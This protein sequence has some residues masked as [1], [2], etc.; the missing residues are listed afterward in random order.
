[1]FGLGLLKGTAIG[2]TGGIVIGLA[3]KEACKQ[4]KNKKNKTINNNSSTD[5]TGVNTVDES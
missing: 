3:I 4:I 1:M 2:L 5:D